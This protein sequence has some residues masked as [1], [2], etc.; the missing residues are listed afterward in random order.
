[1]VYTPRTAAEAVGMTRQGILKAIRTGRISAKKNPVGEWEID[2]A[3]LHR[4]Y[5]PL[6]LDAGN[7]NGS[8]ADGIQPETAAL[9][10][11]IE[12]LKAMVALMEQERGRERNAAAETIDDLRKDRDHW[13]HQATALIGDRRPWWK[14]LVG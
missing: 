12:G 1:M 6:K 10:A 9:Q 3:E 5:P 13:R 4:V 2:P 7:D 8:V 11:Q 14:R